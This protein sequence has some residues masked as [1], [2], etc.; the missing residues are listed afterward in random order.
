MARLTSNHREA[1]VT[2]TT[3]TGR[4]L[5]TV[6]AT[7][8]AALVAA[9]AAGAAAL[10]P[11]CDLTTPGAPVCD[12]YAN[13]SSV[14]LAGIA[15]PVPTWRFTDGVGQPL[16]P[17]VVTQGDQVRI[18]IHNN[19]GTAVSLAFP[20][21]QNVK[22]G[23]TLARGA[24]KTG[25][26]P[27]GTQDYV[28]TADRPGT[29]LYEAGPTPS[30]K[31][32]VAMGL[33]G[34]LVVLPTTP[35]LAYPAPSPAYDSEDVLVLSEI[36]PALNTSLDPTMFN[37]RDYDPKFVL[38]NGQ[39]AAHSI[40]AT[41]NQ[42]V[43]VR[44]VNAGVENH[45]AGLLGLHQARIGAN[46][47]PL[48]NLLS[49]TEQEQ[50]GVVAALPAGGTAETLIQVPDDA[51]KAGFTYPVFDEGRALGEVGDDMI[52]YLAVDGALALPTCPVVATGAIPPTVNG[53][54]T[55]PTGHIANLAAPSAATN[56]FTIAGRALECRGTAGE[57][58][59]DGFRFAIDTLPTGSALTTLDANGGFSISLSEADVAGIA[60]GGQHYL[61]VQAQKGTTWGAIAA[62]Q[63]IVDN[64]APEL[65][66]TASPAVVN[67]TG[68]L[69]VTGSATDHY[70][71]ESDVVSLTW[72]LDTGVVTTVP[73]A[74]ADQGVTVPVD[75]TIPVSNLSE[76][77]H[78]VAVTATDS[79]GNTSAPLNVAVTVDA[80]APSV[81]GVVIEQR[82]PADALHPFGGVLTNLNNGTLT[83]DPNFWAIRVYGTATDTIS[84]I[85]GMR[86]SFD[87]AFCATVAGAPQ[88]SGARLDPKA[89][90]WSTT[91][92]TGFVYV[93]LSELNRWLPAV[94]A[95]AIHKA[96]H[97]RAR[98]AAGNW[99]AC[100]DGFVDL[101]RT[102]P[103]ITDPL[104]LD[105]V[106]PGEGAV[107]A[108]AANRA[109]NTLGIRLAARDPQGIS[110]AEFFDGADPGRGKGLAL[111][112]TDGKLDGITEKLA[113][114]VS[115]RRWTPGV[116]TIHARVRDR[117]GNWSVVSTGRIVVRFRRIFAD[118]FEAG[119]AARHWGK[120]GGRRLTVTP[121]ARIHGRY[122]LRIALGRASAY[123]TD[124]S[125][126]KETSYRASFGI[127]TGSAVT[128]DAWQTLFTGLDQRGKTAV[129][130]QRRTTAAGQTIRLVSL[131]GGKQ[132]VSDATA[133]SSSRH[134]IS[135][136]WF[137]GADGQAGLWIDGRQ[138][139]N[140]TN[141]KNA[142]QR[143]EAARLGQVGSGNA[144]TRGDLVVDDFESTK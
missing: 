37:L 126:R 92:E 134:V 55:P 101:D 33:A 94:G 77:P 138:A 102:V 62:I 64:A 47:R 71:G 74:A 110:A 96:F 107:V 41:Q 63:L 39:P 135:I 119:R 136:A 61:I 43:L 59:A 83:F 144:R 23:A 122:G 4:R 17:L 137:A 104:Q 60:N 1:D 5:L 58:S 6:A 19:L 91:S 32:Q 42:K 116:H 3:R 89:G 141:L 79:L 68:N 20:Q 109:L 121:A 114:T 142:G 21:L 18:T 106:V 140:M 88:I 131:R 24:D 49:G 56:V 72:K 139:A 87:N 27:T 118:G 54:D 80:T 124:K 67:P 66:V 52:A 111:R 78:T 130:V 29:F 98:D 82:L 97:V 105:I 90:A 128:G 38:V 31:Q 51:A 86:G 85:K 127:R 132:V 9:P 46:A 73:I 95:P 40:P 50:S 84:S 57:V 115:V 108:R 35:G 125:P 53:L 113:A 112:A 143:V 65:D 2:T 30:G 36:D 76:G 70:L 8:A 16:L 133:L 129:A 7:A 26:A 10:T 99:S 13:A 117:A 123:V 14:T 103:V 22:H 100:A 25:A 28:F 11:N 15:T 12:V 93:P 34:A 69:V 48:E 75:L 45:W 120:T 81:A 44:Y